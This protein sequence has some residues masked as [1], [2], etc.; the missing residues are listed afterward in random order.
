MDKMDS[1]TEHQ[2]ASAVSSAVKMI[3]TGTAPDE[4]L[5]KVAQAGKFHPE[6]V[7]RMG[8]AINVS[9]TLAHLKTANGADKAASFPLVDAAAVIEKMYPEIPVGEA[10]VKAASYIP[11]CYAH[12]ETVNFQKEARVTGRLDKLPPLTEK[13]ADALPV[14]PTTA[15]RHHISRSKEL[16]R[17]EKQAKSNYRNACVQLLSSAGDIGQLIRDT[18][19]DSY[20]DIE[21][22]AVAN[23][24]SLGK[25]AMDMIYKAGNLDN[26]RYNIK[27]AAVQ[28]GISERLIWNLTVSP[29]KEIDQMVKLAEAVNDLAVSV[30]D[31]EMAAE[32]YYHLAS[33]L[34]QAADDG[35]PN[36]VLDTI[37]GSAPAKKEEV[38]PVAGAGFR[39]AAVDMLTPV[40]TGGAM[41]MG[42]KEPQSTDKY[43]DA[44]G[45]AYDPVHRAQMDEVHVKAMLNDF[46]SNDPIISSY[47]PA[48][49]ATAYNSI[50]QMSPEAAKQPALMRGLL[51]STLQKGGVMEPF[52]VKQMSDI[53]NT[54]KDSVSPSN[55]PL[56]LQGAK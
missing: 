46:I 37:L 27:R 49:A 54:M 16:A 29:M 15:A 22:R 24:G 38:F 26:R 18:C 4:A 8:E 12:A 30:V 53:E 50:A 9:R 51:R 48:E 55:S 2:V 33:G 23:Y 31:S 20:A 36:M 13:K 1:F 3:K 44:L 43:R 35:T 41:A 47:D 17:L 34:K 21:R 32:K 40:L 25:M 7:K 11:G 45:E 39:K 19:P 56:A 5:Y 42:L 28:S 14:D 10:E 52:E 6:I